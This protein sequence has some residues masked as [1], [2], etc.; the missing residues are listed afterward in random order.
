M[1]KKLVFLLLL[2]I[3][4]ATVANTIFAENPPPDC[5]PCSDDPPPPPPPPGGGS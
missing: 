4:F 1:M 3:Q 5:F 2:T